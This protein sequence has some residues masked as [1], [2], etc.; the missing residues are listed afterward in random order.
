[1]K[2]QSPEKIELIQPPASRKSRH[3][4]PRHY[5]PP[6]YT[7][8]NTEESLEHAMDICS[9]IRSFIVTYES[10]R[11]IRLETPCINITL[12]LIRIAIFVGILLILINNKLYQKVDTEPISAFTTKLDGI[13]YSGPINDSERRELWDSTDLRIPPQAENSI[14]VTTNYII[15]NGQERA[16]CA[17]VQAESTNCSTDLDCRDSGQPY[18]EAN[19]MSIGK[20]NM[21]IGYC[22]VETWCPPEDDT[23]PNNGTTAVLNYIHD[24]RVLIKNHVYFPYFD[25]GRS[26]LIE[27]ITAEKLRNGCHY[28]PDHDPYCPIFQI[29]TI[30]GLANRE[31]CKPDPE[32]DERLFKEMAIRGGVIAITV[33][34]DCDY[35][36]DESKCKPTYNFSRIDKNHQQSPLG[37]YNFHHAKYYLENGVEKRKL[38][39]A[40]GILFLLRTEAS[41]RKFDFFTFMGTAEFLFCRMIQDVQQMHLIKGWSTLY[42]YLVAKNDNESGSNCDCNYF[43]YGSDID[44]K[45]ASSNDEVMPVPGRILPI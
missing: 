22:I 15:T 10:T 7:D 30:V 45:A 31:S 9:E 29:K 32:E 2:L 4:T 34:W 12:W 33:E 44:E 35:D 20:C 38:I 17:D 16:A 1:M 11:R 43:T 25:K 3:Y 26:N 14:F 40:F 13:T 21:T 24:F 8:A 37:G 41:A 28:D 39:K 42:L 27:S 23:L 19:G 36:F 6:R 18:Q 5:T